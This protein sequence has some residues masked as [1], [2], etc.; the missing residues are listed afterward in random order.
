MIPTVVQGRLEGSSWVLVTGSC[1]RIVRGSGR[2]CGA[3]YGILA[4]PQGRNMAIHG[5]TFEQIHK[6]AFLYMRMET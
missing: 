5:A 4:L 2:R 6:R 1:N 3:L